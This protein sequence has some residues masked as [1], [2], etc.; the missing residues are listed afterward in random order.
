MRTLAK[1]IVAALTDSHLVGLS[2]VTDA[3]D[4]VLAILEPATT[5]LENAPGS[6]KVYKIHKMG[7]IPLPSPIVLQPGESLIATM[8]VLWSKS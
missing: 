6:G 7:G 5:L 8:P 4:V 3:E 2:D 1:R